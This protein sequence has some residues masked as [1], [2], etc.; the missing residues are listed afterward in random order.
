M[1]SNHKEKHDF[2]EETNLNAAEWLKLK[3]LASELGKTKSAT[4]SHCL[5]EYGNSNGPDLRPS[6][7]VLLEWIACELELS[8]KDA[9]SFCINAFGADLM[10]KK[11]ANDTGTVSENTQN[12]PVLS[13]KS[14]GA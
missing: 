3:T 4:L 14:I 5:R 13:R 8:K 11:S 2:R 7:A 6:D 12:V 1:T 9:L 10:R